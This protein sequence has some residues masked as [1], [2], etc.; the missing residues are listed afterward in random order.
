MLSQ[1]NHLLQPIDC[2]PMRLKNRLT[3]APINT[4]LENLSNLAPLAEF[5]SREAADGI[6]L[7][8][9]FSPALGTLSKQSSNVVAA[10]SDDFQRYKKVIDS[11][12]AFDCRIALQLNHVGQDAG[13][14]FPMSSVAGM[15]KHTGRHYYAA[16]GFVVRSVTRQFEHCAQKAA[17]IGFDA[18]EI[19][20]SGRSFIASF[21][22]PQVNTRRD[23]WG[24]NQLGRFRLLLEIVKSSKKAMGETKAL[25]VRFN[26]LE[27]SPKGASWNEILRLIQMLR[28]A[29][30]DYLIGVAG[31]FEERV[32]TYFHAIPQGVWIP[33]YEALAQASDLPVFFS[34]PCTDFP[35]LEAIAARH[36]NAVFSFS[37]PLLGDGSFIRKKLGLTQGDVLPWLDH[38][39]GGV[40]T[41][42]LRTRRLLSLTEPGLFGRFPLADVPTALPRRIAV[43]GG[44]LT[45]MLFAAVAAGRGHRVTLFEKTAE[46]GGQLH[47]LSKI[48]CSNEYEIWIELLKDRLKSRHVNVILNKKA[49]VSELRENGDFDLYVVATGSEPEI[50]DIAGINASN[51]L[52]YEELL[53]DTPVGNRVALLGNGRIALAVSRYLLENKAEKQLSAEAWRS[54]WGVGDIREHAGGVL[55]CIPEMD[56]A[57]RQ[58]YLIELE[59]EVSKRLLAKTHNRWD[60]TWLLMRGAQ[61]VKGVNIELIDN[62]AVRISDGPDRVH[63]HALRVDH[64]VVCAGGTP[65]LEDRAGCAAGEDQTMILGAASNARGYMNFVDIIQ[66][67]YEKAGTL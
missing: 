42:V 9:V 30:A 56:Q 62:Y 37:S 27:L 53:E 51:V 28:I 38:H 50:P 60:Y 17:D 67:V 25:G 14:L 12:H 36:D 21:L 59:P 3:A 24:Q 1:W 18:V 23:A 6:S 31:G 63:R 43:L 35:Q 61:T 32:P 7:T 49:K 29:G 22:S 33:T 65:N 39:D 41:D 11:V 54:A 55:G 58:L 8:T 15:S 20:A 45:G 19:N 47:W 52:T 5:L 2:G 57:V 44:G 46:L 34:D 10:Y 16:P 13:S 64:V 4:G 48:E 40:P 66:Q 26:L